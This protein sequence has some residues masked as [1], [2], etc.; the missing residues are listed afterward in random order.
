[1][2]F[3]WDDLS[4][5]HY[6]FND[7]VNYNLDWDFFVKGDYPFNRY[8][9]NLFLFD[10]SLSN[11]RYFSDFLNSFFNLL[12]K[13]YNSLHL[14]YLLLLNYLLYDF[15]N[16]LHLRYFHNLLN[17]NLD[18]L[19]NL[20]NLFDYSW[21]YHYFLN[22]LLNFH[23]FGNLN[24]FVY[25]LFNCYLDFFQFLLNHWDLNDFINITVDHLDVFDILNDW[26]F[27]LNYHRLL[28]YL[29][30]YA[31][32]RNDVRNMDS[33]HNDFGHFN[34]NPYYSVL[35]YRHFNPFFNNFYDFDHL[36]H[37]NILHYLYFL[38]NNLFDNFFNVNLNN[39]H[40]WNDL[41]NY[42]RH[43]YPF[44]HLDILSYDLFHWHNLFYV[45]RHFLY[46]F[47]HNQ[48]S[49]RRR[50]ILFLYNNFLNN[51]LYLDNL[52]PLNFLKHNLLNNQ[53]NFFY[54]FSHS[55]FEDGNFFYDLN[56]LNFSDDVVHWLFHL[57]VIGV[58]HYFLHYF[59]DLDYLWNLLLGIHYNLGYSWDLDYLFFNSGHFHE[60]FYDL[61]HYFD[62]F[63]WFVNH[64]LNNFGILNWY[65]HNLLYLYHLGHLHNL[66][67]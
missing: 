4:A 43:F 67:N 5:L 10:N 47:H 20:N 41:L 45:D 29:L 39:L 55:F 35:D 26:L 6:F 14:D 60:L 21:H 56:Y 23:H 3:K 38:W 28:H 27:H 46:I 22:Y 18:Q 2:A 16:D 9:Y 25:N 19:R 52:N 7:I 31:L 42:Y 53:L 49:A 64:F 33:L 57:D 8:F 37:N 1:M 59:L 12:D 13:V 34:G 66:F 36:L 65:L 40:F 44:G 48:L 17:H 62:D 58:Y 11:N 51:L 15:L 30:L 54:H 61:V 63:H 32:Y 24:Y 50:D